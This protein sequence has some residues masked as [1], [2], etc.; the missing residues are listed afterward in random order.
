[1]LCPN[2]GYNQQE[3]NVC[4]EC[5]TLLKSVSSPVPQGVEPGWKKPKPARE[6][7]SKGSLEKTSLKTQL[8][9]GLRTPDLEEIPKTQ[10]T[11]K[12]IELQKAVKEKV[13]QEGELTTPYTE[14]VSVNPL[15][16]KK[17]GPKK[18]LEAEEGKAFGQS[19]GCH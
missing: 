16:E 9:K 12:N 18:N 10:E 13:T 14:S 19:E 8:G 4:G 1:M 3:G 17:E 15:Q 5:H 6:V 2:C 11:Q 7:S